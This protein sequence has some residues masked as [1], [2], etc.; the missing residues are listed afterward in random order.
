VEICGESEMEK[1]GT[2]FSH[3]LQKGDT[4]LLKGDLGAGK[5]T[6]SRGLVRGILQDPSM[7]VTSP[8][9]LLDNNY[10]VSEDFSVH[11]MDLFR[12]P[13][14]CDLKFLN[15]PEVF[16][17]SLCLVEWP[18]RLGESFTPERYIN[19]M[20]KISS[21]TENRIAQIKFVGDE[22][23]MKEEKLTELL[24]CFFKTK[25]KKR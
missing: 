23:K 4:L 14:N 3:F 1:L 24:T 6:F 16:A 11:H 21:G 9:Y 18:D 13:M 15:I 17:N 25:W 8:S 7:I 19:L 12:L 5:S 10:M 2:V 22:W 20:L